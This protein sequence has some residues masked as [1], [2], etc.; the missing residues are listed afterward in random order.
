M[1]SI[2]LM[3]IGMATSGHLAAQNLLDTTQVIT[4][5]DSVQTIPK[6]KY[7]ILDNDSTRAHGDYV[8][9]FPDGSISA[10]GVFDNGKMIGTFREFYPNGAIQRVIP[11]QDGKKEGAVIVLTPSGDTLQTA[12]FAEPALSTINPTV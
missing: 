8:R 5:Y 11:Y 3:L 7:F 10:R 2:I 12:H 6:A 9:Y 1:Q 4:Y